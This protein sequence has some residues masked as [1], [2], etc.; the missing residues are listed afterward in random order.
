MRAALGL[1]VSRL[2]LR[3]A[4]AAA[5]LLAAALLF[6]PQAA[7]AQSFRLPEPSPAAASRTPITL[8]ESDRER[9]LSDWRRAA[10]PINTLALFRTSLGG[11][12]FYAG[13]QEIG[14]SFA[15]GLESGARVLVAPGSES[16]SRSCRSWRRASPL[17]TT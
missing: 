17:A 5:S 9:Y 6:L 13:G 7:H 4:S 2:I 14:G 15:T 16:A 8:S 12:A 11:Q 1:C 3:C 10:R